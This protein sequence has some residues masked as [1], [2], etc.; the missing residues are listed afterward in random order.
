MRV[1]LQN[2]TDN[3]PFGVTLDGRTMQGDGYRFVG[4]KRDNLELGSGNC[5]TFGDNS[6]DLRIIQRLLSILLVTKFWARFIKKIRYYNGKDKPDT[7]KY[8]I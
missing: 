7:K 3:S 2:V 4:H 1:C 8:I 6:Y 5:Y